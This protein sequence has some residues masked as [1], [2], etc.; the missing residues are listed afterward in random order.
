[1]FG[2]AL[3]VRVLKEAVD[4]LLK[5]LLEILQESGTFTVSRLTH[6]PIQHA[7]EE[8]KQG[9][10]RLGTPWTAAE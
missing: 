5:R 4:A 2:P 8:D 3:L 10:V 7:Q 9:T 1:M 6:P